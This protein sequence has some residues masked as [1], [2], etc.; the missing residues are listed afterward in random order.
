MSFN[1]I[2]ASPVEDQEEHNLLTDEIAPQQRPPWYSPKSKSVYYWCF[3]LILFQL[4]YGLLVYHFAYETPPTRTCLK[5]N[6]A[7]YDDA[8]VLYESVAYRRAG[9]HDS[10]HSTPTL[11]EGRPNEQNDAA[12][13]HITSVGVIGISDDEAERLRPIGTTRSHKGKGP[14]MV[15]VAMFHQLHCLK[16]LRSQLWEFEGNLSSNDSD[17][18]KQRQNHFDHCLDYLRQVIMCHGDLT[19]ITFEWNEEVNGYLA[20]HGDIA[21]CRNFERVFHWAQG[22]D[23]TDVSVNGDHDNIELTTSVS[24]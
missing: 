24:D 7:I 11:F 12:W 2:T 14:Y 13:N 20:H 8:P 23:N 5:G 22:R 4:L 18:S 3:G 21:K 6:E 19:P 15:E 10:H 16:S 9:F 17:T 1:K